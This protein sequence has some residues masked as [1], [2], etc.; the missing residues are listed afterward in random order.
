MPKLNQHELMKLIRKSNND[1]DIFLAESSYNRVRDHIEGGSAFAIIT[2]DRHERGSQENR[3]LYQQLKQDFKSAGF[4]FTEL[5]GGFKE[6][7]KM[8]KDPETGELME[9][10]LEEPA[11]VTENAVLVTAHLRDDVPREEDNSSKTLFDVTAAMAEKYGQ[12][13]F[14]FGEAA[15]ADSGRAFK[16]IR[17]Y[18]KMGNAIKANW[19]GPW[20]SVETVQADE[21][22]WSRIK[23]KHF[24][25]KERKKTKAPRSWMDALKKSKSGES[26]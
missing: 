17:A 14:I 12:E 1:K 7:T 25:L 23:G 21:D 3:Q 8:V 18:D 11:Y 26:W 4:P 5:K 24:Q 22:F 15:I 16:D 6:T 20:D 10:E 2:S 19:A 9:V 13:A